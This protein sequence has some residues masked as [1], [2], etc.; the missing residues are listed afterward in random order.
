MYQKL[1][2]VGNLGRD[3]EMR[4]LPSGQ[5][6]TNLNVATNRVY[7]KD[8]EKVTETT[9]FRVSVWG[10]QGENANKYLKQ[11]SKVLIEGRLNSDESGNPRTY[12]RN[13][14]TTGASFEMTAQQVV[15]LSSRGDVVGNAGDEPFS[16]PSVED[17]DDIP[18]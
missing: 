10:N 5:A 16:L 3:P 15:Y 13:D 12:T 17:A 18:F 6:V 1:T 7:T 14:G 11:G 8:N 4:Y 9:W 2:I